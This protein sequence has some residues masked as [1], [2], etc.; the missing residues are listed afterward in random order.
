MLNSI[1]YERVLKASQRR[2]STCLKNQHELSTR[3]I[4]TENY[5]LIMS[6]KWTL[7]LNSI[8]QHCHAT[9]AVWF[10]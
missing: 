10:F 8:L 1:P 5:N 7:K 3:C 9:L 6:P 4:Y 2:F